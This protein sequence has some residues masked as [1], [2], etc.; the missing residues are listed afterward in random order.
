MQLNFIIYWGE[1]I[2]WINEPKR[3]LGAC[4]NK[5]YNMLLHSHRSLVLLLVDWMD[6]AYKKKRLNG[7]WIKQIYSKKM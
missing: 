3:A 5:I 7:L 2:I 6:Y 4:G 1:V